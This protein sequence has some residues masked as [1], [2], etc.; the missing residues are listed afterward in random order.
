VIFTSFQY[1]FFFS[2]VLV[3]S[4]VIGFG[5]FRT[6]FILA[7]SIYFYASNNGWQTFLLIGTSL[8]DYIICLRMERE[9]NERRRKALVTVSILSN[10]GV[11]CYFKYFHFIGHSIEET[12]AVAGHTLHWPDLKIVLP[13]GI[14]FYTFEALSYTIDVYRRH[15]RAE[16][17]AARL[18]FLVSFFPHLISGPIVRA[19]DFFPQLDRK[20]TLSL[21]QFESGLLLI[22]V[23]MAK[24]LLLADT[25][26]SFADIAFDHPDQV[27]T[28]QAWLGVYAFAFQIYFDF[29]GYTDIARGCARLLGYELP[30][31]FRSPYGASSITDFWRRW[32]ISL[33]SWLRDYLYISLGGNRMRSQWGVYRNLMITMVLGGLWH[34][35]AWHF[36]LWGLL[37]GSVLSLERFLG[38]GKR[39]SEGV[40][41][42]SLFP[43]LFTFQIV[44]ALWIPFR[45]PDLDRAMALLKA[46]AGFT[47]PALAASPVTIGQCIVAL[48]LAISWGW[49]LSAETPRI[50]E[51]FLL[52]PTGAKAITYGLVGFAVALAVSDVPKAFIYFQF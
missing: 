3:L 34:G 17:D 39:S 12:F 2:I 5:R 1:V 9:D 22:F 31:N 33:S 50:K 13:I 15:I 7:A 6:W 4:W 27:S 11:L 44:V 35:A 49:Q 30:E 37:H 48:I 47:D 38:Y 8:V 36:M 21:N 18:L 41:S 51:R 26:V 45:S 14:S 29:S 46:M 10:I 52:L 24:K 19:S 32:H 40:S 28:F 42:G 25:V 23:G 43:K 20:P 16:R